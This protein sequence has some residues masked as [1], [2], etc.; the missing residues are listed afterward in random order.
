MEKKPLVLRLE[1]TA[2]LVAAL[3]RRKRE[4]QRIIAFAL[5]EP[6][7][8]ETRALEKMRRKGVDAIVANALSTMESESIAPLLL[9]SDGRRLSPGEMTK[10]QFASWL[11]GEVGAV[12]GV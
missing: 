2:D 10:T 8:L 9:W 12:P 1:P 4:D 3:A 6:E 7:Q 5:E 11:I